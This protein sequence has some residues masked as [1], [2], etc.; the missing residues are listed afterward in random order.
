MEPEVDQE[1]GVETVTAG[2]NYTDDAGNEGKIEASVTFNFGADLEEAVSL[3]GPEVVYERYIRG[4]KKDAGNAIRAALNR[5][6]D[7]EDGPEIDE[8]PNLVEAEL[9]DWRPDV[10]RPRGRKRK[11]LSME[12]LLKSFADLSAEKQA[13]IIAQLQAATASV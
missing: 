3:Y 2:T 11:E 9:A 12:D 4:V 6:L 5:Y 1:N 7:Q 10:T 13:E 8:I